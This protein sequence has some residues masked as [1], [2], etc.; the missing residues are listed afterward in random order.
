MIDYDRILK[1]FEK[2]YSVAVS[3][4]VEI[5]NQT[6]GEKKIVDEK[7][8]FEFEQK[9]LSADEIFYSEENFA[10]DLPIFTA[11]PKEL[12]FWHAFGSLGELQDLLREYDLGFGSLAYDKFKIGYN[13][14]EHFASFVIDDTHYYKIQFTDYDGKPKDRKLAEKVL[15]KINTIRKLKCCRYFEVEKNIA[16]RKDLP[17]TDK[18]KIKK[19]HFLPISGREILKCRRL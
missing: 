18:D 17:P 4:D 3:A 2:S 7:N 1:N 9:N 5:E 6:E 14:E 15:T 12:N 8:V 13:I 19:I 10:D 11:T 16:G